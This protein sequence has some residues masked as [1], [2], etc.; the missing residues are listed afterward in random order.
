MT[1]AED[2]VSWSPYDIFRRQLT[3]KGSFAQVNCMDRSLAMLRSGRIKHEGLITH[4]F[5]L[6]RYGDALAP[7]AATRPA[8]RPSSA[9][10]GS[11]FGVTDVTDQ[12]LARAPPG[13]ARRPFHRLEHRRVHG[14]ARPLAPAAS[15]ALGRSERAVNIIRDGGAESAKPATLCASPA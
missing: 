9:L 14:M 10:T 11:A 15:P 6:D 7:S 12:W 3:I 4:R 1:D 13:G 8:S 2:R 5:P